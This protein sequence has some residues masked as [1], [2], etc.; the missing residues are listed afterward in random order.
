MKEKHTRS[1][2][3]GP[4]CWLNKAALRLIAEHFAESDRVLSARSAYLALSEIAS[5]EQSPTFTS[6]IGTIARYAGVCRRTVSDALQELKNVGL[7]AITPQTIPGSKLKAP[8]IYTLLSMPGNGCTSIGN[9]STSIGNGSMQK[10]VAE[11]LKNLGN[12]L[13][14][15]SVVVEGGGDSE[16]RNL[17]KAEIWEHVCFILP[18]STSVISLAQ[19]TELDRTPKITVGEMNLLRR[20]MAAQEAVP[21]TQRVF[22]RTRPTLRNVFLKRIGRTLAEAKRRQASVDPRQWHDFAENILA[23]LP[24]LYPYFSVEPV[25][26]TDAQM[27]WD[28]AQR[29]DAFLTGHR[30]TSKEDFHPRFR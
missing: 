18:T 13:S 1:P 19:Q 5:N 17:T 9:G 25:P 6:K 20:Y 14:E 29:W 28:I 10:S 24:N 27:H 4:W 22:G 26:Q 16:N 30:F 3:D 8:S 12:N 2:D 23:A 11:N 21:A 15:Q 7:L